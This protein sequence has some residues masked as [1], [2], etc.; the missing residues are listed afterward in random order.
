MKIANLLDD[1]QQ[2]REKLRALINPNSL[3]VPPT[4]PPVFE[5]KTPLRKHRKLFHLSDLNPLP[6][7]ATAE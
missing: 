1:M 5:K 2:E 7:I 4:P 3:H 6:N